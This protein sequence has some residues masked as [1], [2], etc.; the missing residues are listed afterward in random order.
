MLIGRIRT[1]WLGDGRVEPGFMDA[2]GGIV[3]PEIRYLSSDMLFEVWLHSA[4]IE[5]T[6]DPVLE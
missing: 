4:E 6:K 5:V 2:D 3:T 1:L